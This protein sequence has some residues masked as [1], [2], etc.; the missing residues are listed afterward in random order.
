MKGLVIVWSGTISRNIKNNIIKVIAY[1]HIFYIETE[2]PLLMVNCWVAVSVL[3]AHTTD[4]SMAL[5]NSPVFVAG[6]P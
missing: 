1:L 2:I 5:R 4:T 3:T 6:I